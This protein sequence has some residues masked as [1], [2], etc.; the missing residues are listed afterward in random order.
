MNYQV[1]IER[2]VTHSTIVEVSA[3]DEN[4]AGDAALMKVGNSPTTIEW[5]LENESTDV[6]D[7]DE[8]SDEDDE[9]E[10]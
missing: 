9:D 3:A 8:L 6:T 1:R 2:Q 5:E 7:C 4:S 10:D